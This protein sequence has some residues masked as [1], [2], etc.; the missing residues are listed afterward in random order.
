MSSAGAGG[1]CYYQDPGQHQEVLKHLRLPSA[2][3][4]HE[5]ADFQFPAELS[6]HPCVTDLDPKKDPWSRKESRRKIEDTAAEDTEEQKVTWA[7]R[8]SRTL[9]AAVPQ[10]S[11]IVAELLSSPTSLC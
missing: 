3:Q 6:P 1:L 4:L 11:M 10:T 2:D 7:N 9:V 5:D 8:T